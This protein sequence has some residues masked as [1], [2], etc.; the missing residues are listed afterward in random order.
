L[1]E[2][3]PSGTFSMIGAIS[4]TIDGYKVGHALGG[5]GGLA[6]IIQLLTY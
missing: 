1:K 3:D 4:V 6:L 5:A 2:Y